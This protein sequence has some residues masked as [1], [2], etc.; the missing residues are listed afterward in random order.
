MDNKSDISNLKTIYDQKIEDLHKYYEEKIKLIVDAVDPKNKPKEDIIKQ[1]EIKKEFKC[2]GCGELYEDNSESRDKHNSKCQEM[3]IMCELHNMNECNVQLKRK[4]MDAHIENHMAITKATPTTTIAIEFKK[5]LYLD[6]LTTRQDWEPAEIQEID[7]DKIYIK[8]LYW[9]P[10]WNEWIDTKVDI[11]RILKYGVITRSG[12]Y[13]GATIK[14]T[15]SA[16]ALK[17]YK[18]KIIS[19]E[20]DMITYQFIHDNVIGDIKIASSHYTLFNSIDDL[21]IGNYYML[22]LDKVWTNVKLLKINN[23]NLYFKRIY[24]ASDTKTNTGEFGIADSVDIKYITH[25]GRYVV[26]S[27]KAPK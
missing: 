17:Q 19:I 25:L 26:G 10:K 27:T 1:K 3:F 13:I 16:N 5:G 8:Y 21:I 2:H 15:S 20:D 22:F 11:D 6:I 7:G 14:V 9:D 24:K 18:A 4:D 23:I 12:I